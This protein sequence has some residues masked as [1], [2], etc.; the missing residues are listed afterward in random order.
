MK[1]K[2]IKNTVKGIAIAQAVLAPGLMVAGV[3][4]KNNTMKYIGAVWCGLVT[5]DTARTACDAIETAAKMS[6][7]KDEDDLSF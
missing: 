5:L 4:T 2:T 7:I 6:G 3:I 1:A